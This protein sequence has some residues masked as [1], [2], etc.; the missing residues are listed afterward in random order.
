MGEG[1]EESF[2]RNF[3]NDITLREGAT[4]PRISLVKNVSDMGA[5][6]TSLDVFVLP[7]RTNDPF[8]LAA[9][10]AMSLGVATVVTDACGIAGYLAHKTDALIAKADDAASLKESIE[11]LLDESTRTAL[12][13]Q[14][15]RTAHEKFSAES[16]VQKY[17]A[18]LR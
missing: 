10:E 14:G 5:F 3:I 16:M 8:G 13:K 12:A 2:L 17:E 9:A 1:P 11:T 18:V 7:S 6:Y 4:E 15:E